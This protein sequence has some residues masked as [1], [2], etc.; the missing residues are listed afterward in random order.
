MIPFDARKRAGTR[1]GFT[2]IELLV[3]IAI[4]AILAAILFPVFAKAREKSYQSKC[5]N[6]QRQ[7]A[8]AI[9]GNCQDNDETL[10]LPSEWVAASGM[11]SD[12]KVFDCPTT[13]KDGSP[14]NPNYGMNAFLYDVDETGATTAL[15]LGQIDNPSAVELT[16]ELTGMSA[17]GATDADL[18]LRTLKDQFANP[19]PKSF[20]INGFGTGTN[21]NKPHDGGAIISYLDG[22]VAMVRPPLL[23]SGTTGFNIPAGRGRFY[24]D[25]SKVKDTAACV[26]IMQSLWAQNGLGSPAAAAVGTSFSGGVYTVAADT[27]IRTTGTNEVKDPNCWMEG[28]G[29]VNSFMME[30]TLDA[31]ALVTW[32]NPTNF[33]DGTNLPA[34]ADNMT[35][36][37]CYQMWGL[38]N[39]TKTFQVGQF[40]MWASNNHSSV[41]YAANTWFDLQSPYMGKKATVNTAGTITI[42]S[43]GTIN[44]NTPRFPGTNETWMQGSDVN[45]QNGG[46][47]VYGNQATATVTTAGGTTT[48]KGPWIGAGTYYSDQWGH[49]LKVTGGALRITKLMVAF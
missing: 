41:G 48:L 19:F 25:F 23:G 21:G 35:S 15:A 47:N 24:V 32:A 30:C 45:G 9:I 38:D 12:A 11:S 36:R 7:L 18:A 43:N 1:K 49:A 37:M 42:T 40:K 17:A 28:N 14:S 4:I 16:G 34:G 46:Y 2:L 8:I 10:P 29:S 26:R 27:L 44:N 20:S 3:V 5:M 22:H 33:T 39:S 13:T 31:G 6:N